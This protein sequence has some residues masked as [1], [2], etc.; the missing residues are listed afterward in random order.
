MSL[1]NDLFPQNTYL[2]IC[3]S[4]AILLSRPANPLDPASE[5]S[6]F[7][8]FSLKPNDSRSHPVGSKHSDVVYSRNNNLKSGGQSIANGSN[9]QSWTSYLK[10]KLVSKRRGSAGSS[11]SSVSGDGVVGKT[12]T[13]GTGNTAKAAAKSNNSRK[14]NGS[15][16]SSLT[17]E[18][19]LASSLKKRMNTES[20]FQF[21]NKREKEAEKAEPVKIALPSFDDE[22][23]A[24]DIQNLKGKKGKHQSHKSSQSAVST[25]A[26]SSSSGTTSATTGSSP[27]TTVT[28]T[29]STSTPSSGTSGKKEKES[30]TS[31]PP[32]SA[33][34]ASSSFSSST[35]TSIGTTTSGSCSPVLHVTSSSGS[36]DQSAEGA[37]ARSSIRSP[38]SSESGIGSS[39]E[40]PYNPAKGRRCESLSTVSNDVFTQNGSYKES[41]DFG[42]WD[43]SDNNG[44]RSA[45]SSETAEIWDSPITMFDTEKALMDLK[46]QQEAA[47]AAAATVASAT[48]NRSTRTSDKKHQH[49]P[50]QQSHHQDTAVGISKSGLC[51]FGPSNG[52]SN[53]FPPVGFF[54]AAIVANRPVHSP[55]PRGWSPSHKSLHSC[56]TVPMSETT[57]SPFPNQKLI[58]KPSSIW[59]TGLGEPSSDWLRATTDQQHS[60]PTVPLHQNTS[61]WFDTSPTNGY[62]VT[63]KVPDVGAD[64]WSTGSASA[65]S[66]P[67]ASKAPIGTGTVGLNAAA[68]PI[69]S[70]NASWNP[71]S[72]AGTGFT[73]FGRNLWTP[74]PASPPPPGLTPPSATMA[75][76]QQQKPG[77]AGE[78]TPGPI[79]W[80]RVPDDRRK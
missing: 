73:L 2:W 37:A 1:S 78:S 5:I 6:S 49:Q 46:R 45:A 12:A 16:K 68:S 30:P 80:N 76:Q 47:A 66:P 20:W 77:L 28:S 69:V 41:N 74:M 70:P 48:G 60:M 21:L 43:P 31:Q 24:V 27:A 59:D 54:D 56:N 7:K 65:I 18:G 39:F 17:E 23:D 26:S 55:S 34:P 25:V 67:V 14:K 19:K 35:G 32:A 62:P 64:F 61:I 52:N 38:L 40:L 36:R 63:D 22:F 29:S 79:G 58:T 71:L 50:L 75:F 33:S 51:A 42:F 57:F 3:F 53:G 10:D 8:P 72:G 9:S 4:R 11:N 44:T 15:I 13:S